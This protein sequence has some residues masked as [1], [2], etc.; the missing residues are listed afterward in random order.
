MSGQRSRILLCIDGSESSL[1]AAK[2]ALEIAKLR[3]SEIITL[4]IS[5]IPHSLRRSPQYFWDELHG[6]D[7]E[8]LGKWLK[9]IIDEAKIDNIP[10]ELKVKESTSSIQSEIVKSSEEYGVDLV[11]LGSTGRSRLE[12]LLLG[13]VALGVTTYA[14]CS[15][16]VVR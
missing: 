15:V 12:R 9:D 7:L 11:V 4:Y 13:S 1:K 14:K 3:S 10:I 6:Y 8:Q 16:L 5:F 2:K